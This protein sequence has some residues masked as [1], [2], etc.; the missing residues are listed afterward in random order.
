M[1][2]ASKQARLRTGPLPAHL[3][4]RVLANIANAR[5]SR[6]TAAQIDVPVVEPPLIATPQIDMSQTQ[7]NVPV[8]GT[9][10]LTALNTTG[11]TDC[12]PDAVTSTPD[13]HAFD[14]G[15]HTSTPPDAFDL[16]MDDLAPQSTGPWA[17]IDHFTGQMIINDDDPIIPTPTAPQTGIEIGILPRLGIHTIAETEPPALLF[18]DEDIR[19]EWLVTAVKEFLRYTPFYGRLAKVIDLFLAQ[20]ARLGY[21]NLVMRSSSPLYPHVNN[22]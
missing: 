16:D 22:F 7:I 2:R 13:N 6:V 18:E 17:T 21:P 12:S 1:K 4:Q 20:E 14:N 9:S 10:G 11:T 3:K 8:V 5:A 15:S 19:P